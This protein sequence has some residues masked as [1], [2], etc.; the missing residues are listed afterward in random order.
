[1]LLGGSQHG[2]NGRVHESDGADRN[3]RDR[4]ISAGDRSDV[5]RACKVIP[6][7]YEAVFNSMSVELTTEVAAKRAHRPPVDND[8]ARTIL[9]SMLF[10]SN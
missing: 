7:I 1:M 6:D 3:G 5:G 4:L 9:R 8:P 10:H 2:M